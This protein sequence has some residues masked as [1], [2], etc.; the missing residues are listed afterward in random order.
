[1]FKLT[2]IFAVISQLFFALAGGA[3]EKKPNVLIFLADDLGYGDPGFM[4]STLAETPNLDR[5]AEQNMVFTSAYAPA[6]HCS[7]SRAGILTGQYP[8]R[9]H[10][11]IWIGGKKPAE[12]KN[13]H[14]PEQKKFL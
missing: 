2:L 8:A 11:T 10:I 7:P 6:P 3:E 14:L 13:M 4:G 9:L 12:Y 5:F 1:M